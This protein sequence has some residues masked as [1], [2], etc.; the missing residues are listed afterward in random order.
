MGE[1]PIARKSTARIGN[2]REF[3]G[4]LGNYREREGLG[5]DLR[6]TRGWM[7]GFA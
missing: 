1:T 7:S 4:I 3:S 6:H 2:F 5:A